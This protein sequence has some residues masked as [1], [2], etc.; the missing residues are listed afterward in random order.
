MYIVINDRSKQLLL[1]ESNSS[2][3]F[4]PRSLG[5]LVDYIITTTTNIKWSTKM[6][7]KCDY[8]IVTLLALLELLPKAITAS[9]N[10]RYIHGFRCVHGAKKENHQKCTI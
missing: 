7:T 10:F 1:E 2:P 4:K 6:Q 3:V 8:K 5:H 9:Q